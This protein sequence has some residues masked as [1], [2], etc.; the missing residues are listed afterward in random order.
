MA[1][2]LLGLLVSTSSYL[3]SGFVCNKSPNIASSFAAAASS[4]HPFSS[5][6]SGRVHMSTKVQREDM[7][8]SGRS[9]AEVAVGLNTADWLREVDKTRSSAVTAVRVRHILV[10]TESLAAELRDQLRA[11]DVEYKVVKNKIT[12]LAIQDKPYAGAV[13]P[14]LRGMVAIA[15]SYEDPSAAAKIFKEFVKVNDKLKIK[16]GVVEGRTLDAQGV[17]DQLATMPGKNE[18]RAQLLCT[19][20]APAQQFVQQLNAVA[21]NFVYLLKAKETQED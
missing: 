20:Q 14:T 21:Q 11:A 2:A 19:L 8:T 16:A 4:V 5:R 9:R 3:L 12:K 15:W 7:E 17:V 10:Q 6:S 1:H 18:I 13:L